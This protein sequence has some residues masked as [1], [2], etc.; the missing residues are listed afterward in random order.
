MHQLW[1]EDFLLETELIRSLAEL[2]IMMSSINYQ[3]LLE[4]IQ[5]KSLF[6]GTD[7]SK[8]IQS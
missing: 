5:P 7:N 3:V 8:T 2:K 4:T 1:S 6:L